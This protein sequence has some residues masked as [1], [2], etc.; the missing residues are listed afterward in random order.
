MENKIFNLM[1]L[2]ASKSITNEYSKKKINSKIYKILRNNLR[3]QN[4]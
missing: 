1:R 4:K 3:F 2:N